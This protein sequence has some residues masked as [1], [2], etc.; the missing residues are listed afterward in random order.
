M[1]KTHVVRFLEGR[2]YRVE[3]PTYGDGRVLTIYRVSGTPW[4]EVR[5][6]QNLIVQTPKAEWTTRNEGE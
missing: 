3:H 6:N 4:L 2:G 5:V 1:N